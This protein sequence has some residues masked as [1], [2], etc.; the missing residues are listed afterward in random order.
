MTLHCLI[1]T[2]VNVDGSELFI[3]T[4]AELLVLY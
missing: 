4:I 2:T 3:E 1:I